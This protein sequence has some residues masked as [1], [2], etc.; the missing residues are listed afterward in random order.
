VATILIQARR[1]K[2]RTGHI[3][4]YCTVARRGN[5]ARARLPT[6]TISNNLV[7]PIPYM[8]W[9]FGYFSLA[10]TYD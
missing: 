8:V 10:V 2:K 6:V 9:R 5:S 3:F 1:T 4:P 7:T